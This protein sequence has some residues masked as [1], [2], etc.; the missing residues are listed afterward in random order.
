MRIES[1]EKSDQYKIWMT[2]NELEDLRRA[3]ANHRDDLIIQLGGYVGLRA[4]EV[5][6]IRPEHVKRTTDGGYFRLRVPK[7]KDT[8]NG[9]GKP[10]DA[11]L[12]QDVERDI[13]RFQNA[14]D[15]GPSDPLVDLT[16]R[17]V[18]DIV[19]RTAERAAKETG[20]P[21]FRHVSSHDLRRRFAQRLL[22]D[23]NVNPRVVPTPP[24]HPVDHPDQSAL[25]DAGELT[26]DPRRDAGGESRADESEQSR[27][28]SVVPVRV[29]KRL[30]GRATGHA[31]VL[32][33]CIY[34]LPAHQRLKCDRREAA[35]SV[36]RAGSSPQR[37]GI[38]I[39]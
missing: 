22:V 15:I 5:P 20:D 27:S 9:E 19:K 17:A 7:G 4:F 33:R 26:R 37:V 28:C 11:Y 23:E 16:P 12:P 2:D 31:E 18:R 10:R 8:A 30:S 29:L 38:H 1:T 34:P 21:D 35:I 36:M 32:A 25:E 3:A 14:K 6:Q 39:V 13:H 24:E